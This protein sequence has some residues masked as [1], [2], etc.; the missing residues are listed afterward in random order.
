MLGMQHPSRF[1][2]AVAVPAANLVPVPDGASDI[3]TALTEPVACVLHKLALA[4][5]ALARR[6]AAARTLVIGA[7]A[8]GL[9]AALDLKAWGARGVRLAETD[10]AGRA[11]VERAGAAEAFDP[12]GAPP[13]SGAF[14]LVFDASVG[15]RRGGLPRRPSRP[16]A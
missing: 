9:L 16:A 10:P 7:G 11:T 1:A 8:T 6:V 5:R 12:R 2:E 15:M 13:G 14:A 3:A 4:A